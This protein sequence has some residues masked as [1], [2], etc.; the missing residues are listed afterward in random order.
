MFLWTKYSLAG[1]YFLKQFVLITGSLKLIN[2]K[3]LFLFMV[4]LCSERCSPEKDDEPAYT[5]FI[6]TITTDRLNQVF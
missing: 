5:D 1:K 6:Y 2:M 3:C 4:I